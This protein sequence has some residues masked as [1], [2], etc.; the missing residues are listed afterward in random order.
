MCSETRVLI[1][2]SP[3]QLMDEERRARNEREIPYERNKGNYE[4]KGARLSDVCVGSLMAERWLAAL[5]GGTV[6]VPDDLET[7][8]AI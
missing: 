6:N 5:R 8:T 7:L 3:R 2:N 1:R 4:T